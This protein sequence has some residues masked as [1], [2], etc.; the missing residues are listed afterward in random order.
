MQLPGNTKEKYQSSVMG[1]KVKSLM[2]KKPRG[3]EKLDYNKKYLGVPLA[4][5]IL[6]VGVGL[7]TAA[8]LVIVYET[9]IPG[10]VT[11]ENTATGN[12][13]EIKIYETAACEQEV[14]SINFGSGKPGN[15]LWTDLYIKNTGNSYI[16]EVHVHGTS[17]TSEGW[18]AG[19]IGGYTGPLDVGEVKIFRF[20]VGIEPDAQPGDYSGEIKIICYGTES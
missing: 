8:T 20:R 17:I 19:G 2:E 13:Y 18:N 5:I 6:V 11:V 3:G 9:S 14:S 12:N 15:Y 1:L 7:A 10:S 4:M 16:P